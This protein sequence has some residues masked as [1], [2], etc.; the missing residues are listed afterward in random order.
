MG[1]VTR[2]VACTLF[3]NEISDAE[4]IAMLTSLH[5]MLDTC[6]T[7]LLIS[8][9]IIL[10]VVVMVAVFYRRFGS[11]L[12]WYDE[13][14]SVLMAWITYYGAALA[15]LRRQHIGFDGVLM[16]LPVTLRLVMVVIA[17]AAVIAFFALLAW[18]GIQVLRV[19]GD[20]FLV[21][22]PWVPVMLTQSV[23]PISA[24]LFIICEMAS[25]PA[26]WRS[27]RAGHAADHGAPRIEIGN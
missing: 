26:Y 7:W 8:L 12:V 23:I 4:A 18:T 6:L 10:T 3:S 15:A 5:K 2:A 25:L 24:V 27:V 1:A 9:M 21:S 19:V 20:E 11:S 16:R 13:V 14:A 17:E 22:L